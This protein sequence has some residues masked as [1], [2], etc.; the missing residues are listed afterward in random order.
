MKA[1]PIITTNESAKQ[2]HQRTGSAKVKIANRVKEILKEANI[3]FSAPQLEENGFHGYVL[4]ELRKKSK[5]FEMIRDS[6]L[7][8][9]FGI[10]EN[11]L[12][13]LNYEFKK[14]KVQ[15][16]SDWNE[17]ILPD[18]NIYIDNDKE[19]F[20]Y[21]I[22]KDLDNIVTRLQSIGVHVNLNDVQ[23]VFRTYD[24]ANPNGRMPN[25]GFIKGHLIY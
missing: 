8:E 22:Y 1:K 9:M 14:L 15:L 21:E 11:E 24:K 10:D 23:R 18:M 3:P 13:K 5:A 12:T 20:R 2:A 6:S 17:V 19:Q 16:S 7:F 25:V 4:N